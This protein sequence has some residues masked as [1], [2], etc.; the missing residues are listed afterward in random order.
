MVSGRQ[1]SLPTDPEAVALI[2]EFVPETVAVY[3]FGSTVAARTHRE[4]DIDLAVLAKA[5]L[6][7]TLRFDV[8]RQLASR[9]QRDVD[10]VDLQRATTVMRIQIVARGTLL[11]ASDPQEKDR[12]EMLAYS[13]YARLN[14]ERAPVLERVHRERTVYGR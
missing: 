1:Q 3:R 7:P 12:F 9:L 2:R 10:L 4:S 5:A 8:Q 6:D 14:E 13:A 11:A